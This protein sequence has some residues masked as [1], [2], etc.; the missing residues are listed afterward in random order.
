MDTRREQAPAVPGLGRYRIDTRIST[1]TF[2]TRHLFG[3]LPVRGGFA[4]RS[5]T[6]DVTE[7]L[8]ES[9][10]H[11]E[12]EAASF[13]T[14]NE[15]RDRNVRSARFLDA[16]RFPVLTFSSGRVGSTSVG[17]TLT[18]HGVSRPVTLAVERSA[19][20]PEAFTVRATTRLDR[21]EF[22]VTG[23]RGM[24]GRLLDVTVEI[25]CAR[26]GGAGG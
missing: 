2:A 9:R 10:V 14:G 16:G 26:V 21:T 11:V 3:L 22:G 6:V 18:A 15:Q 17:G 23:S 19:V 7:P 12:I 13:S 8:A 1:V 24:T 5:G 20:S 25:T 4:V